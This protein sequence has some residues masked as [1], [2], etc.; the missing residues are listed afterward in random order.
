L[1]GPE[2]APTGGSEVALAS[3]GRIQPAAVITLLA[4]ARA[5]D[6]TL[7][8]VNA[9]CCGVLHVDHP[10]ATGKKNPRI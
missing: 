2:L 10:M 4:N 6:P 8:Y 3:T 9:V 7:I 1:Y 5:R